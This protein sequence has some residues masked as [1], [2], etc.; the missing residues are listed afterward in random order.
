MNKRIT[1]YAGVVLDRT[2]GAPSDDLGDIGVMQV[3]FLPPAPAML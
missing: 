2:Q 3:R 1:A